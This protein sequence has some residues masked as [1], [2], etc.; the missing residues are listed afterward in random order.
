MSDIKC[1]LERT[2]EISRER[3]EL[4]KSH[5]D[6][7]LSIKVQVERLE[8]TMA[9]DAQWTKDAIDHLLEENDKIQREMEELKK[10]LGS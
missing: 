4:T 7:L 2:K 6:Q 9:L 5:L 10:S 1:D 8:R 3:W